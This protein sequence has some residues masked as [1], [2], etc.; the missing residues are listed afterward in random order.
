[1][2][3]ALYQGQA[4]F[5]MTHFRCDKCARLPGSQAC[6]AYRYPECAGGH[7]WP[8]RAQR[9][10]KEAAYHRRRACGEPFHHFHVRSCLLAFLEF[11]RAACRLDACA[12]PCFAVD[13]CKYVCMWQ[14]PGMLWPE[15][16]GA[17][18][19]AVTCSVSAVVYRSH[20]RHVALD[21]PGDCIACCALRF[22]PS[23]SGLCTRL[24]ICCS[25][26]TS[27]GQSCLSSNSWCN[28]CPKHKDLFV[29]RL[30]CKH[31]YYLLLR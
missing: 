16:D 3:T 4:N 11:D 13:V 15:L 17:V 8:Q 6:G 22:F 5:C 18:L 10:T 27:H 28:E 24:G 29:Q 7:P 19:H 20:R 31:Q 30:F 12:S 26:G 23:F 14:L 2:A 25:S 21:G 1:M 9:G